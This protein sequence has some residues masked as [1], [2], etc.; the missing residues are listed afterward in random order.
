VGNAVL[1]LLE[2][3]FFLLKQLVLFALSLAA[4]R[5]VFYC[6][7]NGRGRTILVKHSAGIDQHH[8][9]ADRWEF[10]LNFKGLDGATLPN[11]VFEEGPECR[12]VPLP[13]AQLEEQP[14]FRLAWRHCESPVERAARGK[15]H[16]SPG[17][18]REGAHV[19]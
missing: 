9:S 18:A 15:S 7:K 4:P 11:N 13:V 17:R 2:Q 8:A 16:A 6:Q 19:W 10:V 12:D 5:H 14:A 3:N 1:H